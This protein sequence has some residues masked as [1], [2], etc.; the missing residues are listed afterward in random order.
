MA[1]API[2]T[3]KAIAPWGRRWCAR[4]GIPTSSGPTTNR[5][6]A[7]R[8]ENTKRSASSA[9]TLR[10]PS[11]IEDHRRERR[12]GSTG[13][14]GLLRMSENAEAEIAKLAVSIAKARPMPTIDV[15]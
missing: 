5:F 7:I 14:V 11:P 13:A 1:K 4:R 6:T 12:V 9:Q 8:T 3:P 2:R 10:M 15:E